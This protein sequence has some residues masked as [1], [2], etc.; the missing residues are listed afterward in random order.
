M[1]LC[2]GSASAERVGQRE[3]GQGIVGQGGSGWDHLQGDMHMVAARLGCKRAL[4]V[5]ESWLG[6]GGPLLGLTAWAGLENT[7]L[8]L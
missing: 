1:H 2:V 6:P 7:T 8:T 5:K 3:V 4:A